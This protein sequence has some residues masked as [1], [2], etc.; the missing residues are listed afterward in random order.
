MTRP[1]LAH[2]PSSENA[3]LHEKD[4]YG[5]AMR[6]AELVRQG[7][8]DEI[9][10]DSLAEELED[11]GKS[12][13]RALIGLLGQSFS[14]II[15]HQYLLNR[16]PSDERK[17]RVD[18]Q[19]FWDDAMSVLRENPGL[20]GTMDRIVE[21]AWEK[22]RNEVFRSFQE[23]EH[24]S[25]LDMAGIPGKCPIS[26]ESIL[27]GDFLPSRPSDDEHFPAPGD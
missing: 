20:K 17:W 24:K 19:V 14:H 10:R 3:E 2:P 26:Q 15:K 5:W 7:R 6:S 9:D 27:S 18:A 13:K 4:F 21:D 8:F 11:M 12:E 25:D 23:F 16:S 1:Q 22:A